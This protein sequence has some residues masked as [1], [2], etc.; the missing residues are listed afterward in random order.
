MQFNCLLLLRGELVV[1]RK[2]NNY[3]GTHNSP[4]RYNRDLISELC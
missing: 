2:E 3:I 1:K 4:I